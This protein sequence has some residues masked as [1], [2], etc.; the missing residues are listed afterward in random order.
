MSIITNIIQSYFKY[1]NKTLKMLS[2][3]GNLVTENAMHCVSQLPFLI[4]THVKG[5][6]ISSSDSQDL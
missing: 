3:Y 4:Q 2:F 6:Q 1:A 5:F